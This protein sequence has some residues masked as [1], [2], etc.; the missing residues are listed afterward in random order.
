[1][2]LGKEVLYLNIIKAICD[3]SIDN[4]TLNGEKLKLLLIKSGMRQGCR[5][6]PLLFNIVL[7][8]LARAIKQ[9]REI[10]G[11]KIGKE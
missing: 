8:F 11:I 4:I 7:E 2:K 9:E 3:K 1:M 5:L 10:K 6:S